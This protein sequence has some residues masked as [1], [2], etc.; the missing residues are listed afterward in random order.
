MELKLQGQRNDPVVRVSCEG[1][2]SVM[3]SGPDGPN[4]LDDLL[5]PS[6]FA[7]TVLVDLAEATFLDSSGVSWL[8]RCQKEFAG[9][10]GTLVLHSMPPVVKQV[11]DLLRLNS[12]FNLASDGPAAEA[13]AS[14]EAS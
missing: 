1:H 2:I 7:R 13:L 10:G 3:N 8:I 12:L 5:G 4:P 11:F 9:R 14:K 6:G